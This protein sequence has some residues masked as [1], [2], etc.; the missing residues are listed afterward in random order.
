MTL[1]KTCPCRVFSRTDP[2]E[3]RSSMMYGPIHVVSNLWG[4]PLILLLYSNTKSPIEM[5]FVLIFL[6]CQAFYCCFCAS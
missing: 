5:F 3:L 6:S 2:F 4:L 1:G